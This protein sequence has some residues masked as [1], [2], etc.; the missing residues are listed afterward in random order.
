[1]EG[2]LEV[3]LELNEVPDLMMEE[4]DVWPAIKGAAK[5]KIDEEAQVVE[6]TAGRR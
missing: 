5:W 6:K 4:E 1:M 2:M 3:P